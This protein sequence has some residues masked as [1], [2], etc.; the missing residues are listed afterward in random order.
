MCRVCCQNF[1]SE[2]VLH[3]LTT[4]LGYYPLKD[5]GPA[6]SW[7]YPFGSNPKDA[8]EQSLEQTQGQGMTVVSRIHQTESAFASWQEEARTY[9]AWERSDEGQQM[10][11]CRAIV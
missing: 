3:V 4:Y 8:A 1:L 10:H 11:Q 7:K 2:R 6:R 9:L 5:V